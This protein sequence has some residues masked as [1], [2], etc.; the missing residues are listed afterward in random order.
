LRATT[1]RRKRFSSSSATS[2]PFEVRDAGVGSMILSFEQVT[3]GPKSSA[4][5]SAAKAGE[6]AAVSVA[7]ENRSVRTVVLDLARVTI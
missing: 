5:R 3:G 4:S 6:P 2:R 1:N 7:V